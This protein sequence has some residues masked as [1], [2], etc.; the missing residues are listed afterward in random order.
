MS[1]GFEHEAVGRIKY[2]RGLLK[3]S[4]LRYSDVK[5]QYIGR[6]NESNQNT[7]SK[8]S[9]AGI[10]AGRER[11]RLFLLK[12]KRR[13]TIQITLAFIA[14]VILVFLL[15]WSISTLIAS[16]FFVR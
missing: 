16:D 15:F 13:L 8:L 9:K 10:E 3:H 14:S 11:A 1:G 6:G 12:R 4:K 2:N 5:N 7:E